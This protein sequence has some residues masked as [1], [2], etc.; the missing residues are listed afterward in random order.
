MVYNYLSYTRS[1]VNSRSTCTAR[2]LSISAMC[3]CISYSDH[4][5]IIQQCSDTITSQASGLIYARAEFCTALVLY[6]IF[7][8]I[9]YSPLDLFNDIRCIFWT[10]D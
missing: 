7:L 6:L 4:L 1:H 2:Y 9:Y 8:N 3:M 5:I 10:A